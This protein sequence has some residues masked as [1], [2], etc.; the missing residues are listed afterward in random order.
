MLQQVAVGEVVWK[1]RSVWCS[2]TS[3]LVLSSV[4]PGATSPY[5][6]TGAQLKGPLNRIGYSHNVGT[7]HYLNAWD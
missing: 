1:P 7:H 4:D 3:G 6:D 5:T 2:T